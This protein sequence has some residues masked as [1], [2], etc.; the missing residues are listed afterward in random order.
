MYVCRE[1]ERER[2]R[3]RDTLLSKQTADRSR[4]GGS[5]PACAPQCSHTDRFCTSE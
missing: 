4:S 5:C 3:E 2:E 1:R